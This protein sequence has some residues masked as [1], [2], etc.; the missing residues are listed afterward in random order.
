MGSGVTTTTNPIRHQWQNIGGQVD[1]STGMPLTRTQTPTQFELWP[2]VQNWNDPGQWIYQGTVHG[3][4]AD[5]TRGVGETW[6]DYSGWTPGVEG[7]ADKNMA[8]RAAAI[9][10]ANIA[11]GGVEGDPGWHVGRGDVLRSLDLEDAKATIFGAEGLSGQDMWN[12]MNK[13]RRD[14]LEKQMNAYLLA[15]PGSTGLGLVQNYM[16]GGGFSTQPGQ[17]GPGASAFANWRS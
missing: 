8:D 11:V 7:W 3:P 13:F 1:P 14:A 17:M 4:G 9:T 10:A 2:N 6:T 15:N 16:A 5:T 12:P